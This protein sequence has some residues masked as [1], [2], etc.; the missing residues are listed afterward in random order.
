MDIGVLFMVME[1]R[2]KIK[3]DM[4]YSLG[5]EPWKREGDDWRLKVRA[6]QLQRSTEQIFFRYSPC[7]QRMFEPT[8]RYKSLTRL[9]RVLMKI[10]LGN[11]TRAIFSESLVS[12][13]FW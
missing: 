13:S 8:E 3:I 9:D 5:A 2:S 1:N 11:T 10:G 12:I 7:R 4:I 6:S